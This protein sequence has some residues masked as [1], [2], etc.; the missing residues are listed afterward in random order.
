MPAGHV[1]RSS[2]GL[3]GGPQPA[4]D[5]RQ[6]SWEHPTGSEGSQPG[7]QDLGL[8][9]HPV[10]S[11]QGPGYHPLTVEDGTLLM[12]RSPGLLRK[13]KKG[14]PS[15]DP[16]PSCQHG[17]PGK[18]MSVEKRGSWK[19]ESGLGQPLGLSQATVRRQ[20]GRLLA[21]WIRHHLFC[22]GTRGS[23]RGLEFTVCLVLLPL[24][25]SAA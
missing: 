16:I 20:A 9:P 13:A 1:P 18:N 11:P 4:G 17:I 2:T 10:P 7:E 14:L 19:T 24:K 6:G 8:K 21:A 22:S 12:E 3:Q 23:Q 15:R 25:P 5:W